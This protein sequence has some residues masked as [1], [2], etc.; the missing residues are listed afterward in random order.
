MSPPPFGALEYF[1]PYA[2][3][4]VIAYYTDEILLSCLVVFIDL[5]LNLQSYLD[6]LIIY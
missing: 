4:H 2:I 5:H 3:S 6:Y 1:C